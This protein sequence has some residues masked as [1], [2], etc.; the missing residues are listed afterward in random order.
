M[1]GWTLL[2]LIVSTSVGSDPSYLVPFAFDEFLGTV[3]DVEVVILVIV[4]HVAGVQPA[5]A[6]YRLFG[7]LLVVPVAFHYLPNITLV[8]FLLTLS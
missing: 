8:F 5:F 3:D 7:C 1:S 6:V 4:A 2:V